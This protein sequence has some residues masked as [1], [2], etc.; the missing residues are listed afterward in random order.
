MN[1]VTGAGGKTGRAIIRA[2]HARGEPVRAWVRT[3]AQID[4]ALSA[5]AQVV[6]GEFF[7]LAARESA[8]RDIRAVYH[9][10]P[11][12]HPDEIAIGEAVISASQHAHVERLVYHSVL[13]PQ[14][15]AMSH[16]FNKL[17]VEELL[18]ESGLCYTVLQPAPYMQNLLANWNAI[19][20]EGVYRV[21]YS[22]DAPFSWID[23][24]DVAEVAARVLSE[25]NHAGAIYEL[26]GPD[27]ATPTQVAEMF[28]QALGRPVRAEQIALADW[29]RNA[30]QSGMNPYALDTLSK[31]FA[32]YDKFGLW[33]NPRVLTHLLGRAPATLQDFIRRTRG[34]LDVA[35]HAPQSDN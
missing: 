33:G 29:R 12:M 3:S 13:H 35:N 2:L 21:P 10:C 26:A 8:F 15:R 11:N 20:G 28:A 23:L 32:Y 17:R 22:R 31:M 14:T 27:V 24:D 5:G 6:S 7:D 1:L 30:E 19:S 16:H 18:F 25:D 4:A 34:G 9:I